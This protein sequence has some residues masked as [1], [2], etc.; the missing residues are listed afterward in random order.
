[1]E[2]SCYGGAGSRNSCWNARAPSHRQTICLQQ[3]RKELSSQEVGNALYGLQRLGDSE[4]VRRLIAALTPKV[5]QCR[6]DLKTHSVERALSQL[7]HSG[8]SDEVR[9]LFLAF[10]DQGLEQAFESRLSS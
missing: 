2:A 4:E 9:D 10:L 5:Q 1:M 6:E 8:D 3:C 7:M